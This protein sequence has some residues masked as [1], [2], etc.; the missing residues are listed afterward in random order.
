MFLHTQGWSR[1]Q[2][3]II[4]TWSNVP[5]HAG[6]IPIIHKFSKESKKCSCT[7][8]G[9]PNA[10]ELGDFEQVMFLHTQGWSLY[11]STKGNQLLNVPAHA[12]VIPLLETTWV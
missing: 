11:I 9:D 2:D 12:G 3:T 10:E 7:R 8:R 4:Y 5:A 1:I 6:V